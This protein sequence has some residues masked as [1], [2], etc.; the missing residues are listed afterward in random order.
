MEGSVER[1]FRW[2]TM[3]PG[4]VS[5]CLRRTVVTGDHIMFTRAERRQGCGVDLHAHDNEQMTYVVEGSLRFWLG[6]NAEREVVVSA[7]ELL[8]VPA[9]LPHRVLALEDT[10]ELNVFS[11]P[12][13]DWRS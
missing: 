8:L 10:L 5:D 9:G 6:A 13:E 1:L 7:G 12:R 4:F 11:P 3:A 2:D